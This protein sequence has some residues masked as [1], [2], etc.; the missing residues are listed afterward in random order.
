MASRREEILAHLE[1][2][3]SGVA[4][5]QVERSRTTPYDPAPKAPLLNILP[6]EESVVP[7]D[8]ATSDRT[9]EVILELHGRGEPADQALDPFAV[10]VHG[11][12]L[13]DVTL[14]GLSMN[15]SDVRSE[16]E[17]EDADGSACVLR[18][19]YAIRYLNPRPSLE[20]PV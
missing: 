4:G 13:Q 12:M 6:A 5:L 9:L 8:R 14:G 10:T 16:W 7:H 15:V 2:L 20:R 17:F 3:L 1:T 18:T 11:L 19:A